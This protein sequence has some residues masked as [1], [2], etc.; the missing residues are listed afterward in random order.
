L[1]AP[2]PAEFSALGR[3]LAELLATKASELAKDVLLCPKVA[4]AKLLFCAPLSSGLLPT[5]QPLT[6]LL[7]SEARLL[8]RKP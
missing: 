1:E 5:S 8:P 6:K 2:L 7:T 4:K 3:L